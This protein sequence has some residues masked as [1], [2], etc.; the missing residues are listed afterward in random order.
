[1]AHNSHKRD[2]AKFL[3]AGGS[4]LFAEELGLLGDVRDRSLLHL[5]CNSGQDSLSLVQ[6]GAQVTGVDIS[7][8]AIDF[9]RQLS[10]DSGLSASFERADVLEWLRWPSGFICPRCENAGGW[11]VADG[12][13]KCVECKARTSVTAG[14]LFDRRRTP[15]TVW[16]QVCWEYATAKDGV[17]ALSLQRTLQI[18]SYQ[19]AWAMLHWC[20]HLSGNWLITNSCRTKSRP[21]PTVWPNPCSARRPPPRW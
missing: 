3:R 20:S 10:R 5:Q 14:T 18:G 16:F 6:L 15:L 17:S 4:T 21:M 1:M 7:D 8:T 11:R 19:T 12:G 13:F 9:A 2:Q